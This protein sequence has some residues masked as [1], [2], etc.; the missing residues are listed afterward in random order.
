MIG[1]K[2]QRQRRK[3]QQ[4]GTLKIVLNTTQNQLCNEW[5]SQLKHQTSG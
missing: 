5:S 2:T 1:N 4:I 3:E